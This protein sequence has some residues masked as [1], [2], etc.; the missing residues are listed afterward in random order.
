MKRKRINKSDRI[1]YNR[2]FPID[3]VVGKG[4]FRGNG[5]KRVQ[6]MIERAQGE[7]KQRINKI[8]KEVLDDIGRPEGS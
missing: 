3:G 5:W 6:L 4:A 8:R 2:D 1:R 7:L